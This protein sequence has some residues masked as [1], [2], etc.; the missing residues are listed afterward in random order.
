[1]IDAIV[2][3]PPAGAHADPDEAAKLLGAT[4]RETLDELGNVSPDDLRRSR[5]AKFRS[6]GVYATAGAVG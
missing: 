4:L 1:V 5:R 6:M 3:E 2:P